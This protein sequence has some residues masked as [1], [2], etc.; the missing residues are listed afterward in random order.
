MLPEE[1]FTVLVTRITDSN[2]RYLRLA[3]YQG[4]CWMDNSDEYGKPNPHPVIA[5]M[6]VRDVYR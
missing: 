1:G 3:T 6:P 2:A 4:D 5:W